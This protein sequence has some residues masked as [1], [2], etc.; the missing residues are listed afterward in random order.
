MMVALMTNSTPLF[1]GKLAMIHN[2]YFVYTD[3][4]EESLSVQK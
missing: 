3:T 1:F 4:M 2:R